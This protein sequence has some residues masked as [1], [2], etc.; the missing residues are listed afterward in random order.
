MF[1]VVGDHPKV[2]SMVR[3]RLLWVLVL[4]GI[5]IALYAN[6][7]TGSFVED[8]Y[9][10]WQSDGWVAG[11]PFSETLG[12]LF[13]P[14]NWLLYRPIPYTLHAMDRAIWG[15]NPVG[16]HITNLVLHATVVILVY[17]V[18]ASMVR[19]TLIAALA[20]LLFASHPVHSGSVSFI[21]GRTD[22]AMVLF[23]MLAVLFYIRFRHS[24]GFVKWSMYFLSSMAFVAALLS[25]ETAIAL[26]L[27]LLIY[28]MCIFRPRRRLRRWSKIV[29]P[30]APAVVISLLY[31]G[32]NLLTRSGA[33]AGL[34]RIGLWPQVL[35]CVRSFYHYM[36]MLFFPVR[37]SPSPAMAWSTSFL[38]P[39]A[40][41]ALGVVLVTL[42]V[43]VL[44]YRRSRIL[45]FGL[46][47][48][49]VSLLPVSNLLAL[50]DQPLMSDRYLYL[51]S[52]GFC[53]ALS[54]VIQRIPGI[55][56]RSHQTGLSRLGGVA[57]LLV[58][59][60]LYALG[61]VARN[62][63][64]QSRYS[65]A[66]RAVEVDPGSAASHVGLGQVHL[67][68][69][70]YDQAIS[71]FEEAFSIDRGCCEAY[72]GLGAVYLARGEYG[73]AL[74]MLTKAVT[75]D[76]S[77]A[78][79]HRD[80]GAVYLGLGR[81][82]E[83]LAEYRKA[84]ALDPGR[85][86]THNNLGIVYEALGRPEE[87]MAEYRKALAVRPGF[88]E[89]CANLGRVYSGRGMHEEAISAYG[90]ALRIDPGMAGAH[91]NLGSEY[92][93]MGNIADAISEYRQAVAI[94]PAHA[95]AHNNLGAAYLM[96]GV[97]EEAVSE[98][99]AAVAL[100]PDYVQAIMNLG[101]A[102]A[103]VGK[104]DE[105]ITAYRRALEAEPRISEAH[106]RLADLYRARGDGA[107]AVLH[108]NKAD[109]LRTG[110]GGTS[111]ERAWDREA[112]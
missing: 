103:G 111:P 105:A 9:L 15:L 54:S 38:Q 101:A 23:F 43:M 69:G 34:G 44:A 55:R 52:V 57:V 22:V 98:C 1:A 73:R 29:F 39:N 80:L 66:A 65:L 46:G 56:H 33:L 30:L 45:S 84:L 31:L 67:G 51:P 92:L 74:S 58:L 3:S 17:T 93:K 4:V 27:V 86:E 26:P 19:T 107:L 76:G 47:W 11:R 2:S 36:H 75:L 53:L 59:V 13:T 50:S 81:L 72:R 82:D 10:R 28:E 41:P 18:V 89:A 97:P 8:D 95:V 25:K 110:A 35:T 24:R 64:W 60:A 96:A 85:A 49:M 104:V 40:A 12:G 91:N 78:A 71:Q 7:L 21:A 68:E 94:N 37:I 87:A 62:R 63:D 42:A 5:S 32:F 88:A 106:L 99:N 90:E 112:R 70:L 77:S 16:F 83:A 14:S 6:S 79:T 102:Y 61:T 20:S 100:E 48:M 108:R 109:S